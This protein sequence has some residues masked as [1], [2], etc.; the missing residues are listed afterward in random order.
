[1]EQNINSSGMM[2][3]L[4]PLKKEDRKVGPIV[5]VLVIVLIVIIITLYFFGQR[6]NTQN[7]ALIQSPVIS[8]PTTTL[9]TDDFSTTSMESID[10]ELDKQLNNVDFSF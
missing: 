8:T 6:L 3:G 5:G 10:I 7:Q 1:M 9:A 4:P 2:N